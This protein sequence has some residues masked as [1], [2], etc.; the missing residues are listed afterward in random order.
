MRH[1]YEMGPAGEGDRFRVALM[2]AAFSA[3]LGIG[4]AYVLLMTQPEISRAA[5]NVLGGRLVG[6]EW[7]IP[8]ALAG[9][10]TGAAGV[11]IYLLS[12]F[13]RGARRQPFLLLAPLL[14]GLSVTIMAGMPAEPALGTLGTPGFAVP[15]LMLALGGATL[16]Q[17]R[18]SAAKLGGAVAWL[19]P[20]VLLGLGY[21][22]QPAKVPLAALL[23]PQQH[24][25][26]L[27]L[28]F[29][30]LSLGLIALLAPDASDTVP[31]ADA[32]AAVAKLRRRLAEA[33][34]RVR[35][36]SSAGNPE[37]VAGLQA[38]LQQA[39]EQ[40]YQASH[41]HEAL[42][43]AR[44]R[45][46][47]LE[48][49]AMAGRVQRPSLIWLGGVAL[50]GFLLAGI[51]GYWTTMRPMQQRLSQV[52][53]KANAVTAGSAD[54]QGKYDK[55]LSEQRA[56]AE[57]LAAERAKL[58]EAQEKL[59]AQEASLA[60]LRS[61]LSAAEAP[62]AAPAPAA[63]SAKVARKAARKSVPKAQKRATAKIGASRKATMEK[64]ARTR[65]AASQPAAAAK[66]PTKPAAKPKQ[67]NVRDDLA[68]FMSDDPIGGL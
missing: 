20:G 63:K 27:L 29:S 46:D 33:E 53:T 31:M 57:A 34:A 43:Q 16:F 35:T 66:A 61:Q 8:V 68:G 40:L 21:F 56:A 37:L 26:S 11:G 58:K 4:V 17:L 52:V 67:S 42:R 25:F 23:S 39:E 32:Q 14:C 38:R 5:K 55:L 7:V 12:G 3:V 49:D 60:E 13:V 41:L 44:A 2:T 47:R 19:A 24:P 51:V 30:W 10:A 15:A 36:A 50:G 22:S 65:R 9:A 6:S 64:Q 1:A 45:A 59:G 18:G 54:A 62:A 48:A 28:M